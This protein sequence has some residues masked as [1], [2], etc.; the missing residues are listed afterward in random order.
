MLPNCI[1]M[2][3]TPSISTSIPTYSL[4]YGLADLPKVLSLVYGNNLLSAPS[5]Q[6]N[7]MYGIQYADIDLQNKHNL[8]QCNFV[9]F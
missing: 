3:T 4:L 2:P 7:Y 8:G 1:I 6:R 9:P 5:R